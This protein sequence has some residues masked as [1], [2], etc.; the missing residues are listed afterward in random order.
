MSCGSSKP[1]SV[2]K[3]KVYRGTLSALKKAIR[4][5][6]YSDSR[7]REELWNR[8]MPRP[9]N[10]GAGR[11]AWEMRRSGLRM[12]HGSRLADSR[13]CLSRAQVRPVLVVVAHIL[14]HQA[15]QMP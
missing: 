7:D 15:L 11:P 2:S 4:P 14:G 5:R 13:A 1:H 10:G 6:I 3:E 9:R 12:R 8:S